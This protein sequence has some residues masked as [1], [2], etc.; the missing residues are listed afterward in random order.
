L[1]SIFATCWEACRV[2]VGQAGM[3][4]SQSMAVFALELVA[5]AAR[6]FGWR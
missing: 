3:N 2:A 1:G 5:R 4:L 6:Y